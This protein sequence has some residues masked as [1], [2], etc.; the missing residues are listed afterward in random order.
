MIQIGVTGK[1]YYNILTKELGY[2]CTHC[3]TICDELRWRITLSSVNKLIT[4]AGQTEQSDADEKL[5]L[6]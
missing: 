6:C 1:A 5:T 4:S 3:I 2:A